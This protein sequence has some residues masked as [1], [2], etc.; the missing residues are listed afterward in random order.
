MLLLLIEIVLE[1]AFINEVVGR[2]KN[3]NKF[4]ENKEKIVP[5]KLDTP[6]LTICKLFS[7]LLLNFEELKLGQVKCFPF[8][9]E[10]SYIL[11]RCIVV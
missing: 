11:R 5:L 1:N 9:C 2:E 10:G 8:N 4:Y 6:L 7:E 3:Q